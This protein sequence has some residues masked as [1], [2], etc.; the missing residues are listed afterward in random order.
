MHSVRRVLLVVG[1]IAA[2]TA[3]AAPAAAQA[4]TITEVVGG[5]DAPRGVAIGADGTIYV[6]EAG[7]GGTEPCVEHPEL[8][9]ICFGPTGGIS[10]VTDGVATRAG[11]WADLRGDRVG[12]RHR[13]IRRHRR[14]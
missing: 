14:Y 5:L 11:R 2:L 8:G 1:S 13:A 9:K 3:I 12:R 7:E 10:A 4:P 6:A